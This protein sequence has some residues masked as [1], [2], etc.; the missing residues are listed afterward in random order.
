MTDAATKLNELASKL[1]KNI[2]ANALAL[3]E[4][5][6]VAI[7][8]LGDDP[9]RAKWRPTNIKL[10][11]GTTD[12]TKLPKGATIGTLVLGERIMEQPLRVI[13]LAVWAGRQMWSPDQNEAKLLCSSPDA[14]AGYLG[15]DCKECPHSKWDETTKRSECGATHEMLVITEDLSEIFKVSF[16]K[17]N[18]A[19]G[20]MW[21]SK[22]KEAGV[23]IYRRVYG[24]RSETNKQYKQVESMIV[25]YYSDPKEKE[26][27]PEIVDFIA[28]MFKMV[29][30]DR[31]E[32]L[33]V[34]HRG[35]ADKRAKG[36]INTVAAPGSDSATVMIEAPAETGGSSE[37][38][39]KYSV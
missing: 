38:A 24:L 2:S 18:Y 13:P 3:V 15:Y 7:E 9:D 33:D 34:F 37:Y 20:K 21:F 14:K 8:G 30:S 36:L 12:R 17:T 25:E 32:S 11:Q 5:M 28:E 26:V 31:K 39:K 27:S 6:T 29:Q 10:V 4:K 22:M 23:A 19:N 16:A 1:P 35:I